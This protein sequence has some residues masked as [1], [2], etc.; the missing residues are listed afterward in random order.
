MRAAD[1]CDSDILR[2][3]QAMNEIPENPWLDVD[4]DVLT[5]TN[6][7]PTML[8]RQEQLLYHWITAHWAK[9]T[10]EIVDL[11]CYAGGSTARLAEGHRIARLTSKI[12]AYDLFRINLWGKKKNLYPAG[13]APFEG[14]DLL[15]VAK[16]LLEPWSD[17]IELYPGKIEDRCWSGKEIEVLVMDA[18]KNTFT[19]D[20]FAEIFFPSLIPGKSLVVQQDYLHWKQ[21]WIAV[22][23]ER[24][25][26]CFTPVAFA[27]PHTI[28]FLCQQKVDKAVLQRGRVMNLPFVDVIADLKSAEQRLSG[29]APGQGI[30]RLLKAAQDN[31]G[32]GKAMDMVNPA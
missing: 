2:Y 12:H 5:A 6:H 24:M 17:R 29:L 14:D 3:Y 32:I 1:V 20:R 15:P 8:S 23:M 18:S 31:P 13:V 10:G 30:K 7:V 9:G 27:P 21:P 11:G 28:V 22:Q 25:A 16:S 26:E 19:T 4:P